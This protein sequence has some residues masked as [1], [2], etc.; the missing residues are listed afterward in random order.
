MNRILI[1]LLLSI[2]HFNSNE[3]FAQQ[4]RFAGYAVDASSNEKLI[5]ATIYDL[6][7]NRG[8]ITNEYGFFS[9]QT[10]NEYKCRISFVGYSSRILEGKLIGDTI[11]TVE[12]VKGLEIE[13]VVVTADRK[14]TFDDG[15]STMKLN[16]DMIKSLPALFGESDVLKAIQLQP[17]TQPGREGTSGF[18]VRGGSNDQN[19][20]LLDGIPVY[21]VNH[22]FGF[23]SVFSPYAINSAT[24]I[25]GAMPARYGGR[26]SSVVDLRLKE[27]NNEKLHGQITAGLIASSI[28]LDGPIIKDKC[29]FIITARRT[30]FD[31]FSRPISLII[32]DNEA[33]YY[34]QDFTFKTNYTINKR[35]SLYLSFYG[36]NDKAFMNYSEKDTLGT[37]KS[38]YSLG[39]GNKILAF[40]WNSILGK[41]LFSNTTLYYSNYSY[42]SGYREEERNTKPD[43]LL[44]LRELN[45]FNNV[46]D[47]GLKW[48][49][50]YYALSNLHL[51]TGIDIINHN[52][53][54]GASNAVD[55]NESSDL[56]SEYGRKI[57]NIE[58]SAYAEAD[59]TPV[60][61]LNF[62]VGVRSTSSFLSGYS[63]PILQPRLLA[64][65]FV[66]DKLSFSAS[67][68]VNVQYVHMVSNSK[69]TAPTDLWLPVMDGIPPQRSTQ[70]TVGGNYQLAKGVFLGF[71]VYKKDLSNLLE[72]KPTEI[73]DH[74]VSNWTDV[75]LTGKGEA[76]GVELM[77]EK[78]TGNLTGWI[79]YTLAKSDREFKGINNGKLFPFR[80]DRRHN[81]S[82]VASYNFN[83][84]KKITASWVYNSGYYLTLNY[85]SYVVNINNYQEEINNY[86]ERN[87]FLTPSYHRLDLS[88]SSSKVKEKGVRTW[89][90]GLYN[91]YN[92]INPF[93]FY[94]TEPQDPGPNGDDSNKT[95]ERKFV[96]SGMF[97][98]I[99]SVSYSFKF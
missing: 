28:A 72:F 54:P 11:L 94:Y 79:A 17:G 65:Y 8:V 73:I 20:F 31:I 34:F 32:T 3:A 26:L 9:L 19:L 46:T 4:G 85:N 58:L 64:K 21:N 84:N 82:V 24:Y 40:R 56:R 75:T 50:D 97:P 42:N 48:D 47:I 88:Y 13:E 74:T 25:K 86:S 76:K 45:F 78:R 44:Q 62:N 1:L 96:M 39:W 70:F 57:R 18:S 23:F 80:Y 36:G 12:M 49:L 89:T 37:Y 6:N 2:L 60:P 95:F 61:K 66:N 67:Y 55:F 83:K 99:P 14:R 29:S 15:L 77:L 30:Y 41:S 71:D 51:K 33:G 38:K 52:Y 69:Y 53:L 43:S 98:I 10:Q 91:S 5:G 22:L 81:I 27:G 59:Y 92:R 93:S 16:P 68:D 63:Q 90:F 35:N 7:T 87:N